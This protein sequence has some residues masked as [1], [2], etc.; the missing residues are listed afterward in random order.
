MRGHE[1]A[2]ELNMFPRINGSVGNKDPVENY[3]E[4]FKRK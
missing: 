3:R 4:I 1:E 2:V